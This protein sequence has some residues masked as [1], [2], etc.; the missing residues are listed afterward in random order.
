MEVVP[1]SAEAEGAGE[2]WHCRTLT[3]WA[4]G[5]EEVAVAEEG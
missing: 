1:W 2:A 3:K 5:E 4:W